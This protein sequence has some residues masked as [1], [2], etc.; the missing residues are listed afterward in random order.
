MQLTKRISALTAGAIAVPAL[1]F[2]GVAPANA[3]VVNPAVAVTTP[4][5]AAVN[6]KPLVS[7]KVTSNGVPV[8]GESVTLTVDQTAVAVFGA[9]SKSITSKTDASGVF[10]AANILTIKK[11]GTVTVTAT[12]NGISSTS[13]ISVAPST[14]TSTSTLA[15]DA[16]NL[17]VAPNSSALSVR[18]KATPVTGTVNPTRLYFTYT[19]DVSGPASGPVNSGLAVVL[20]GVKVGPNGGTIT[21][22]APG[23]K[24]NDAVLT[25]ATR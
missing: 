13:T 7:V 23:G 17:T 9:A 24:F 12:S 6:Q 20:A 25:I 1:L 19:G 10:N 3:A 5:T 22:V 2:A 8:A 14:S 4:A 16:A 21:A 18:V 15:W 11:A